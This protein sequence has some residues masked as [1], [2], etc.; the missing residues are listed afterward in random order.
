MFRSPLTINSETIPFANSFDMFINS[1]I[2]QE[3]RLYFTTR[4][5][6]EQITIDDEDV[7][8]H[9]VITEEELS[10]VDKDALS[11]LFTPDMGIFLPDFYILCTFVED[12]LSTKDKHIMR[13]ES[14][15][16]IKIFWAKKFLQFVKLLKSEKRYSPDL[17]MEAMLYAIADAADMSGEC[18]YEGKNELIN[19]IIDYH[20][21][22]D[23]PNEE[24]VNDISE[25]IKNAAYNL[26]SILRAEQSS[27]IGWIFWDADYE[28]L[29][30]G[31]YNGL[32]TL[33]AFDRAYSAYYV[34]SMYVSVDECVPYAI[35][36]ALEY[37]KKVAPHI[38]EIQREFSESILRAIAGDMYGK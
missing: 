22:Y 33:L 37:K 6:Y 3:L 10:L 20:L 18:I 26:H 36:R 30:E 27:E 25:T 8:K 29:L 23:E 1:A 7:L 9:C 35:E 21:D 11:K 31:D 34:R 5:G 16:N 28:Y 13:A 38:P 32:Q 17:I 12:D 24:V 14:A 19:A 15:D 2:E 4:D